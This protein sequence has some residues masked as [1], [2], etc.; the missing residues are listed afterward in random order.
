MEKLWERLENILDKKNNSFENNELNNIRKEIYNFCKINSPYNKGFFE[1][2][3]P[4]G[5]GKTLSSFRFAVG[6]AKKHG[7]DRIIYVIPFLNIIEQN[8]IVIKE[9]LALNGLKEELVLE[10][11][12]DG[13]NEKFDT[14][15]LNIVDDEN[16]TTYY[17]NWDEPI[18]FTTM[19][20]FLENVYAG[21]TNAIRRFHN[22][23]N[24]V[25]IFD[26]IQAL[27][28]KCVHMFNLLVKFLVNFANCSVVLCS[29][30]QPPLSNLQNKIMNLPMAKKIV[31]KSYPTL[32]RTNIINK[33]DIKNGTTLEEIAQNAINLAK[34]KNNCLIIVNTKASV[35]K[36]FNLMKNCGIFIYCLTTNL[37]AQHR[38]KKI[39]EIKKKLC[40]NKKII[41]ISTNL[42]EAGVDIDFACVIRFIAG[43]D[44]IVQSAGR[45]NREGKLKDENGNKIL[46]EVFL[47]YNKEENIDKLKELKDSQTFL[48]DLISNREIDFSSE[49]IIQKYY[50][51]KFMQENYKLN[52][53]IEN[54]TN[55]FEL[56][57]QNEK[58]VNYAQLKNKNISIGPI[59]ASFDISAQHFKVIDNNQIS[60][61]V[62]YGYGKTII[63]NLKENKLDYLK[64][65]QRFTVNIFVN[66]INDLFNSNAIEN[67]EHGILVLKEGFYDKNLGV[68]AEFKNQNLI[69]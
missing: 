44:N 42:I 18:V 67:L 35:T 3:A 33:I 24:A 63:K 56:L 58:L 36:L 16:I 49:D 47:Y 26:E 61:I 5:G 60:V 25:I 7:L 40:E 21:G 23:A 15:D 59:V 22:M 51:Y 28:S 48:I 38:L 53:P 66:K 46:G 9:L 30:T 55:Q 31:T 2:S 1:L 68:I 8:A 12:S 4:T 19:V 6:H 45:C 62:P 65:A 29:A 34:E 69:Y 17:N 37:C 54:N 11:H 39:K 13:I 20:Q 14:N 41:C 43:I 64:K 57:S 32:K 10:S 52:Y 27:P 50:K